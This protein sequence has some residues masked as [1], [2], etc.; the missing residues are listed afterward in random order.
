MAIPVKDI[1]LTAFSTNFNDRIV[2]SPQTYGLSAA[3]AA[4]YTPLHGGFVSALAALQAARGAGNESRSLVAGKDLAKK[5]LLAYARE[6]Y[7]IVQSSTTVPN[8]AKIELGVKVP[9]EPTRIPTPAAA[10]GI[11]ITQ[12]DGRLVRFRLSD[13]ENPTHRRVPQG[14]NGA[15]ILSF[16]G[17]ERPTDL[18]L[19]R[20]EGPITKMNGEVLFPEHA[21][22]GTRVWLSA[23]WFHRRKQGPACMP[24]T[25]II[26]YGGSMPMAA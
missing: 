5:D 9:S 11:T 16:I 7:S 8:A 10:P 6:L 2:A 3:Q 15:I 13:P 4:L 1:E 18:G 20:M 24:V 25:A 19:Y 22:P 17:E 23:L 26:N 14:V 21:T 12:I